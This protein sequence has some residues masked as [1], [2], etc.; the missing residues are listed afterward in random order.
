MR[1][2]RKLSARLVLLAVI[3]LVLAASGCCNPYMQD[4]KQDAL[5]IFNV[6]LLV[7]D[8]LAPD[9]AAYVSF[10]NLFTL[11]Y[12]H[13]DGKLIGIG[14]GRAGIIDF[15][16]QD[17][18]GVL[19]YGDERYGIGPTYVAK[20]DDQPT[21]SQGLPRVL[22]TPPNPPLHHTYFDCDRTFVLGWVGLHLRIQLDEMLDFITGWFG[23][24]IMEDDGLP[25]DQRTAAQ[26]ALRNMEG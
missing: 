8:H 24:D 19:L 4:R 13:V 3:A 18:W 17:S 14:A 26:A 16:H 23:G 2:A 5:D 25:A 15:R 7:S 20:P 11:G 10:W 9:F 21:Y 12:A 22:G 1:I 6:G